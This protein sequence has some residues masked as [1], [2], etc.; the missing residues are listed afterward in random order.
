MIYE[1]YALRDLIQ[2]RVAG[3][4]T[5]Q[6]HWGRVPGFQLSPTLA[7]TCYPDTTLRI[8]HSPS[9]RHIEGI[10]VRCDDYPSVAAAV[11]TPLGAVARYLLPLKWPTSKPARTFTQHEPF[12]SA[13]IACAREL[14]CLTP[15]G[16]EG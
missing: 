9:G 16:V 7:I 1:P 6:L 13:I 3:D 15:T 11:Y 4:G 10:L 14:G 5:N 8:T 2:V 12:H